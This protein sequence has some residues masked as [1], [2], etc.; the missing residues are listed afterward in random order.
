MNTKQAEDLVFDIITLWPN[1]EP[2]D[3]E[4]DMWAKHLI[5][6]DL[7]IA[8]RTFNYLEGEMVSGNP[9]RFR[10]AITEWT[11][12]YNLLDR[13]RQSSRFV[14]SHECDG[15]LVLTAEPDKN[16]HGQF[17]PCSDCNPEGYE[18][19]RN[20]EYVGR[21]NHPADDNSDT[22]RSVGF[23]WLDKLRARYGLEPKVR[24]AASRDEPF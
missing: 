4:T 8:E 9:R 6:E 18:R 16:S 7:M 23:G 22:D 3:G 10:P 15:G 2:R 20:G 1:P 21:V 19:W 5:D 17:R 14:K 24:S 11:Q 12:R 13:A